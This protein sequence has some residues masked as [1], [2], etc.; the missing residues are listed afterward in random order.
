MIVTIAS[1]AVDAAK[2]FICHLYS[3]I[4]SGIIKKEIDL[5]IPLTRFFATKKTVP[6]AGTG[7]FLSH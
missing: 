5:I 6:A 7:L 1:A 4:L 2:F 3:P